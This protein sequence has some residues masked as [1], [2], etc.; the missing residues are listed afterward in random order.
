MTKLV[1]FIATSLD[2]YIAGEHGEIDWLFSDEDYGYSDFFASIDALIMGRKT[3]E[4]SLA[5][6]AWPYEDKPAYVLTRQP[7]QYS[8][9]HASFVTTPIKE[10][11]SDLNKRYSGAIWLIGGAEL[12]AQC[13]YETLIDEYVISI[14]PLLLGKGILLFAPGFERN[15]LGLIDVK[16][17]AS[18]LVQL[19]YRTDRVRKSIHGDLDAE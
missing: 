10:L 8:H 9:P 13:M 5:F 3:Y 1:L 4:Q 16:H 6:G 17:F 11:L 15:R 14:H 7:A 18:G 12:V 19:H 2:G